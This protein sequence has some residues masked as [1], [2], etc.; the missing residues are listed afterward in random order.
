MK[1]VYKVFRKDSFG[2]LF[3]HQHN[4]FKQQYFLDKINYPKIPG[5]KIF[6]FKELSDA[7]NI[8]GGFNV[9]YRCL[10]DNIVPIE[11][12]LITINDY[13]EEEINNFWKF[14][15]LLTGETTDIMPIGTVG[16]DSIYLLE[17]I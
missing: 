8:L 17:E 15:K 1:I 2:Y 10:A 3:S 9:I 6:V 4:Q 11:K 16:C 13:T 5:S 14:E 12:R 7:Q